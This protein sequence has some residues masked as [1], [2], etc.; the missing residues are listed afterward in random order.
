MPTKASLALASWLFVAAATAAHGAGSSRPASSPNAALYRAQIEEM[1]ASAKGPFER[2][3]W[4]CKDGSVLPPKAYACRDHGGGVQHGELNA[5]AAAM[6]ADG[7]AVANVYAG[8]DPSPFL[9]P[10]ADLETLDQMLLER[11]LFQLD[12]G[13]IFRGA[14]SYRGALQI[15]DEEAGSRALVLA[16]LADPGWLEPRRFERLRESVRLFPLPR[17]DEATASR[18]RALALQL[19]DKDKP[20]TPIR[21]KI[22]NAPDAGDA[23]QV[24]DYA[25]KRAP[26]AMKKDYESLAAQIDQLYSAEGAVKTLEKAASRIQDPAVSDRL[27]TAA[28]ETK[29][30]QDAPARMRVLSRA[31]SSIREDLPGVATAEERLV[32]LEASLE[33]EDDVYTT[34]TEILAG[35]DAASRRERLAWLG[36]AAHALY[37]VGFVTRRHLDGVQQSLA[38]LEANP[39]L[40][41][42][43]YR[44]ELRFLARAPEWSGR[45]LEFN[46]GETVVRWSQ[47]E[48]EAVLFTQD[49]LRGSPL[50][51]YSTVV[52]SLS[53]DANQLA[54][55]EHELFGRKV[56]AGLRALN[57]GLTRGKLV[58]PQEA[59]GPAGG[60]SRDGIY[61]LPESTADL[62]R[63][64]G[65]LTRGEGSSLSH[66]Q[67]LARNLGIP[68]VV[69]AEELVPEVH[70]RDAREVVLAVSPQGVVQLSESSPEW[71][72]IF[73]RE[74]L[75]ESVVI[76]PDI[77]KLDLRPTLI[78]LT[79]LRA[80]DSGALAGPKGANLGELKH[81]FGDRVPDGFVITFGVFRQ[82]LNEPIQP[83]GPSAWDWMKKEYDRLEGL[84][85]ERK[86]RE[87]AAFL[88]KLRNWI[89]NV[90]PGPGFRRGVQLALDRMGPDGSF[91]VFVRS[92]TNVED[93]PGFTGAGLNLTVFNVVG[94]ENVLAAV[95]QVWASPFTERSF[96]WRQK[97][98][99]DPEYVFPSVVVQ[100]ALRADKSGVLVTVDVDTGDPRFLTVAVNEGVGGGVEGQAAESLK[101]DKAS[102]EVQFLAQATA[103]RRNALL[104]SGGV[105][106]VPASGRDAVLTPDEIGQLV[107]FARVVGS[108]FPS[109]QDETGQYLPADVEFAF[110]DGRLYLVQIRPFVESKGAQKSTYLTQLDAPFAARGKAKVDLDGV[111]RKEA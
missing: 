86:D 8:I 14:R 61:L 59:A 43:G 4:F 96:G 36:D 79:R 110:K 20:F 75:D 9:G 37:G 56:G 54:G 44:A 111:P 73:G 6:R 26:A 68:N 98:M 3:R 46:F 1:K 58:A 104:A 32:L 70:Q 60:F 23:A 66:V 80:K 94:Y 109:L 90:D 88:S 21:A 24:R 50:L 25:R 77:E 85:G 63:V 105:D 12:D 31:L 45:W 57:P 87:V 97:N 10:E 11:F 40:D 69:V 84:R 64:S 72:A 51:F 41:V 67:L 5:K 35:L 28:A 103:P 82:V 49:R 65:I 93:L 83:G 99:K 42:D 89:A 102:G 38:R 33:L 16:M 15:E 53:L 55:T 7:W 47:I 106:K 27:R 108:Q 30:A 81:H 92:D 95:K 107:E 74:T 19:A 34:G 29:A 18:V 2:I 100:K 48:P 71:D 17:G 76:A 78:P 22:H 91:G 101:I 39:A 62:P 52:D 13:W